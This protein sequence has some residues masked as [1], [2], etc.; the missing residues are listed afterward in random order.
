MFIIDSEMS[1]R[2]NVICAKLS[3]P[4]HPGVETSNFDDYVYLPCFNSCTLETA[5]NYPLKSAIKTCPVAIAKCI[6]PTIFNANKLCVKLGLYTN[7]RYMTS[8][9]GRTGKLMPG[10][11][12]KGAKRVMCLL[13]NM[14][15]MIST[16]E[17]ASAELEEQGR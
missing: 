7:T 3:P 10:E 5:R 12:S 14:G 11:F 4:I 13:R 6:R 1:R 2:V 15:E 16:F 9:F 17:D 8:F